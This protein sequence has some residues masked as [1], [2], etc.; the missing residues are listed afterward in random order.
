MDAGN[1]GDAARSSQ[2]EDGDDTVLQS[3]P[4]ETEEGWLAILEGLATI[5]NGV[6][7]AVLYAEECNSQDVEAALPAD[8]LIQL[9]QAAEERLRKPKA[10]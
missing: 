8:S 1:N 7:A 5:V 3:E 2:A 9:M 6:G 10:V 4:M